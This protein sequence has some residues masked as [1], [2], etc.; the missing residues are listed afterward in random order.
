[1]N[2]S[3]NNTTEVC[4]E[5]LH[6][7]FILTGVLFMVL[8][9]CCC[10]LGNAVV[11]ISILKFSFLQT[12]SQ[13]FVF[14]L[15]L[16]D[17][18]VSV[19]VIPFD[20]VYWIQFP[21][22]TLGGY[23]CNLWNSL[24]FLAMTASVLNLLSI[25][26]DRFIAVVYP[27]RYKSLITWKVTKVVIAT[28]WIYS[29]VIAVSTFVLLDP[30]NEPTYTFALDPF[31]HGY[32]LIGNVFLPFLVMITLYFKVYIIA[33]QHAKR[34]GMNTIKPANSNSFGP[35]VNIGRE[36]RVAKTLAIVFVGFLVCW[37]PFEII[38][39]IIVTDG[40]VT[41]CTVEIADTVFCWLAYLHS[42][43]NP[44]LYGLTINKFRRAFRNIVCCNTQLNQE[45]GENS[46]S[47]GGY[48]ASQ[49]RRMK[50]MNNFLKSNP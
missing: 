19:A 23:T 37:L 11:C 6:S 9:M 22:W 12:P 35:R 28:V 2:S 31:F 47:T 33:R 15:A 46:S 20:I 17:I 21:R 49:I 29:L 13:Y 26:F 1:M 36:L 44:V 43:M 5:S 48:S 32:L 45:S 30:P 34:M 24:F 39:V 16:S 27:L 38:S 25:S 18:L 8:V 10:L 40:G 41:S 7:G 50:S 42:T 14:S 4:K 3:W